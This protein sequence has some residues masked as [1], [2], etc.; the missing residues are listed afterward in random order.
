MS[1]LNAE[2]IANLTPRQQWFL[3]YYMNPDHVGELAAEFHNMICEDTAAACGSAA[4][5]NARPV[6]CA[7]FRTR[8]ADPSGTCM[9]GKDNGKVCSVADAEKECTTG[10]CKP[11]FL[12][13]PELANELWKTNSA[14]LKLLLRSPEEASARV[15]KAI[16]LQESHMAKVCSCPPQ[17]QPGSAHSPTCPR[18]PTE[19]EWNDNI[20]KAEGVFTN[21]M[22]G[23]LRVRIEK[24]DAGK[25]TWCCK[26]SMWRKVRAE[27]NVRSWVDFVQNVSWNKPETEALTAASATLENIKRLLDAGLI[28]P[29]QAEE[30]RGAVEKAV[31]D[32]DKSAA[33]RETVAAATSWAPPH[34]RFQ[35]SRGLLAPAQGS[36][37]PPGSPQ[38]SEMTVGDYGRSHLVGSEARAVFDALGGGDGGGVSPGAL[39]LGLK[40]PKIAALLRLEHVT[41]QQA[42]AAFHT[43]DK[44]GD[45]KLSWPE[46]KAFYEASREAPREEPKS[47]VVSS[48]MAMASAVRGVF[49]H[50]EVKALMEAAGPHAST[51][52][53]APVTEACAQV[54]KA[55][56]ETLTKAGGW[57]WDSPAGPPSSS[58]QRKPEGNEGTG[59]TA[60][61]RTASRVAQQVKAALV[62][63]DRALEVWEK[64]QGE[65]NEFTAAMAARKLTNEQISFG[66]ELNMK[67]VLRLQVTV[68]K[69][70]VTSQAD[71]EKGCGGRSWK[72][73]T[74]I[75]CLKYAVKRMRDG[76]IA[77]MFY[78]LR[79]P[80]LLKALLHVT[81]LYVK[82]M[83]REFMLW[84]GKYTLLDQTK[85]QKL[86]WGRRGWNVVKRS[87]KK[88]EGTWCKCVTSTMRNRLIDTNVPGGLKPGD[89]WKDT[90]A[91][92]CEGTGCVRCNTTGCVVQKAIVMD[93]GRRRPMTPKELVEYNA[94]R[95]KE[96]GDYIH[97]WKNLV[98]S[99]LGGIG[100]AIAPTW[101]K[102]W[103]DKGVGAM[104]VL[105]TN[106][107][108]LGSITGFLKIVIILAC[109]DALQSIGESVM[110][111]DNYKMI[112]NLVN[113]LNCFKHQYISQVSGQD[114]WNKLIAPETIAQFAKEIVCTNTTMTDIFEKDVPGTTYSVKSV[115]E[116]RDSTQMPVEN[117]LAGAADAFL[118]IGFVEPQASFSEM[119]KDNTKAIVFRNQLQKAV[120]R[121]G[122]QSSLR[123]S[124]DC[125]R[126]VG[127]ALA[128]LSAEQSAETALDEVGRGGGR[129][130]GRRRPL[131][132]RMKIKCKN[133]VTRKI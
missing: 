130:K 104:Q 105:F 14:L 132:Q 37:A 19:E 83:C 99:L 35:A 4:W 45:R 71:R 82:K 84:M 21:K 1:A 94:Y 111:Y 54:D 75:S 108:F 29:R 95:D 113:P 110:F 48:I 80:T 58:A 79:N 66:R 5:L 28:H 121:A 51:E 128:A 74:S 122:G 112:F 41:T 46:F 96:N 97:R 40:K 78:A 56:E 42:R 115:L 16:N 67:L 91:G 10:V 3:C 131:T 47:G 124:R 32:L 125:P 13:S 68:E 70:C 17:Q 127:M 12:P 53:L 89:D 129:R 85:E 7:L 9:G 62:E 43:A 59:K 102:E 25:T 65:L 26:I 38:K 57:F 55:I 133:N 69:W 119:T 50:D 36:G 24:K 60:K 100:G 11:Q 116:K 118:W 49:T 33:G 72:N 15:E 31:D 52:K 6:K 126:K 73:W 87:F 92:P 39:L 109:Q 8:V 27:L 123:G 20:T 107:P 88:T 93:G 63:K 117:V 86:G 23:L 76:A 90:P 61:A 98:L 120:R 34:Q 81:T 30:W 106:V 2:V 22:C 103:L 101:M 18:I 44:N 114:K 77:G 64:T